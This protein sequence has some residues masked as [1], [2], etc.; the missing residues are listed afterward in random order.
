MKKKK[1]LNEIREGDYSFIVTVYYDPD[2][3]PLNPRDCESLL[4][5]IKTKMK[6][7][8]ICEADKGD[9]VEPLVE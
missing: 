8:D 7:N 6:E 5:Q 4:Q 2:N 3:K 1:T 9:I